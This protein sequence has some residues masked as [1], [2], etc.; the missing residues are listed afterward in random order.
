MSYR[1]GGYNRYSNR[2]S[3]HTDDYYRRSRSY[4]P[5]GCSLYRAS[6]GG[7]L[8]FVTIALLAIVAMPIVGG[9]YLFLG[10]DSVQKVLGGIGLAVG[11]F[12]WIGLGLG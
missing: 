3:Y 9:Y 10:K 5:W 4:S 6:G 1:R 8:G 2:Y 7:A 12:L 11:I